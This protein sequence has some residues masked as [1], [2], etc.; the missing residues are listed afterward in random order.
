MA[1]ATQRLIGTSRLSIREEAA[2]QQPELARSVVSL[3]QY[4]ED[5]DVLARIFQSLHDTHVPLRGGGTSWLVF[6]DAGTESSSLLD[7]HLYGGTSGVA[8]FLAAYYLVTKDARAF[9]LALSTIAPL[10]AK[11]KELAAASETTRRRSIPIGG[12]IGLGAFVYVFTRLAAWLNMPELLDGANVA[13]NL[14]TPDRIRADQKFDIVKGSAG[15]LLCL[16][17][18]ERAAAEPA[19]RQHALD[20][21][22]MCGQHLLDRRVSQESGAR[23]WPV[24]GVAAISGFGHGAAGIAYALVRLFERTGE[25]HFLAAAEEACE[26]E[27]SIYDRKAK[28]WFD[29]RFKRLLE[30]AAWCHGAPGIALG[31]V[32]S[33]AAMPSEAVRSDIQESLANT[34]SLPIYPLDDLCCGNF[35][36]V[37]I[38]HIA[39]QR[40]GQPQFLDASYSLRTEVLRRAAISGFLFGSAKQQDHAKRTLK[41]QPSLFRG[42][43][44]AGYTLLRM[45]EPDLLPSILLLE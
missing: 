9:D 43:S 40:L 31:R 25:K 18:L 12:L 26:F 34:C 32:A 33:L 41:L 2:F 6:H 8:L 13:C 19:M 39:G 20:M 15:A 36:R 10:R 22:I 37:E 27:R 29:P 5:A 24:V 21:A 38:L 4:K 14:I 1:S 30:H 28:T 44:G 35:G 16:L 42:L 3:S 7:A 45:M 17:V 23:A 11:M